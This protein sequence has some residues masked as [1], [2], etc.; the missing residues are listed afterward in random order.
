ML[1]T[2]RL[3][4]M[5]RSLAFKLARHECPEQLAKDLQQA[6][7]LV[8]L[9]IGEGVY[10]W[11]ELEY[12]MLEEISRWNYA[13]KRGRGKNRLITSKAALSDWKQPYTLTPERIMIIKEEYEEARKDKRKFPTRE[14][15]IKGDA[16]SNG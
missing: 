6:A 3:Y 2:K 7:W 16:R 10:L 1:D 9:K 13:C 11:R 14:Y 12:A 8:Y 15:N 5:A 4:R